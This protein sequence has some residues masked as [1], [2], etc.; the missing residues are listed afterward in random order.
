MGA[1]AAPL[2]GSGISAGAGLL[3]GGK[4]A[5]AQQQQGN[6][7]AGMYNAETQ[8]I[9]QLM[10]E[11]FKQAP[12]FFSGISDLQNQYKDFNTQLDNFPTLQRAHIQDFGN[13][14]A[15]SNQSLIGTLRS[16]MGGFANP[17]AVLTD[18][19]ARNNDSN[20]RTVESLYGQ[21][22]GEDLSA[23]GLREGSM[24][25]QGSLLSELGS[26]ITAPLASSLG[27]LQSMGNTYANGAASYGNPW[28]SA[29][30]GVGSFIS[31]LGPRS[32][33][34]QPGIGALQSQP[35]DGWSTYTPSYPSTNQT[36]TGI[37]LP[38][39]NTPGGLMGSNYQMGPMP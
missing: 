15:A 22:A 36:P 5:H 1:A 27:G 38:Q 34:A 23:L 11:Y 9:Q 10:S 26:F 2:I 28:E 18:L 29:I 14:L 13:N 20:A 35:H 37:G 12:Q 8:A 33:S 3:G 30:S 16:G 17:N 25:Q 39:N 4:A 24:S 6:A 19:N 7:A 32:G 31:K 21:M